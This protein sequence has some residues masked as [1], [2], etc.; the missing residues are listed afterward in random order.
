VIGKKRQR[1]EGE[2]GQVL[3]VFVICLVM[4]LTTL[5]LII[6]GGVLRRS[7]QEQWNALDAG[8]L[9]G[10]ESL[11]ANPTQARN[12]ALKFALMNHPGLSASTV[13]VTFRCL[14]GDRNNDGR[15]DASDVPAVCNPGSG[16][17]WTCSAGKCVAV[18]N[19]SIAGQTCNTVVVTGT[20]DTA[21]RMNGVTGINGAAT[22]YTSAACSGLCGADPAVPLDIG[23]II[24]R[25]SSMSDADLNNVKN[26]ALSMLQLFDPTKQYIGMAVLG[27]SQ[28]AA[29]CSGAGSARGLAAAT[30]GS[31]TWVVVPY[32]TNKALSSDYL[33]GAALNANS[34]LV[35]TIQCLDHSSTGTNLGDPLLAMGNELATQGRAGVPKGIILMTDGAANQPNTRSCKYA[36][37]K[38]TT[39]KNMGIE[40]FT[41][42][43][44]VVGDSCSDTDGT[45]RT[46]SASKLLADMATGPTTDNGCTDAENADGDHYFCEPRTSS[47]TSV[48]HA[49]ATALVQGSARLVSLP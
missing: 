43:F 1:R 42:G 27:Q 2:Q 23:I 36:Y 31:G 6:N 24:D 12:D 4:V 17:T 3:V 33:S 11:P 22:T 10:A 9:A 35:R 41:I 47:L 28:T 5:A 48:F 32:P 19:P 49:A 26:A 44:G 46:A 20:V 21:Y 13:T 34:P 16:A 15:P 8:A 25:T 39:V 38:A 37:D 18:C 29:A 7:N 30:A 14:V 45:Y 40:L